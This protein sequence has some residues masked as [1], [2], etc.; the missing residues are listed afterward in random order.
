MSVDIDDVFVRQYESEV[1]VA[2]QRQGALLMQGVRTKGPITGKSTTF[3]VS[4]KGTA[5]PKTRGG[6]VPLMN[7][8]HT[9][10]ECVLNDRYAADTIDKLDEL[11]I[12][13]DERSVVVRNGAF[14]L[15]R[16]ADSFIIDNALSQTSL[17]VGDYST[18]ITRNLILSALDTLYSND[19]PNDGM[20][21]GAVSPNAW[22]H[23]MTYDEFQDADKVG[24]DSLPY[25]T[26]QLP[27]RW[28]GVNW[29]MHTGLPLAS[30]DDRDCY[31]W[32]HDSCGMAYG[33]Q[34]QT[35][36]TYENTLAAFLVNNM[37]SMGACLIDGTG[38]VEIRV[39][40]TAALPT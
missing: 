36:I 15:G 21:W 27:K 5:A 3:P 38:V 13:H 32:H 37:M 31:I 40:D 19:V 28:L 9:P 25:Q 1:H 14:A 29:V 17:F 4:G 20:L 35:V 16:T 8:S 10:V 22:A 12:Y 24:P 23:L 26:G 18:G 39:D 33:S 11:K 6:Q 34:V 2:F 7:I 30:S